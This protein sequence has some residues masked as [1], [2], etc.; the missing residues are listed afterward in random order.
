MKAYV[1][2]D[3][4]LERYAGRFVWLSINTE[5]SKNAE[6]LAKFT[7]PALPTLLVLDPRKESIVLRY[8]GGATA[9]QLI[10]MLDDARKRSTSASDS[11]LAEADKLSAAAKHQ[12]AAKLY[13]QALD[14]AEKS[15]RKFGRTAESL[16]FAL[17]TT[18]Q[19][20]LCAQRAGELYP[21]LIGTVSGISVAATGLG[22]ATELKVKDPKLIALLES[23][24][25][26]ALRNREIELSVD[27]RSGLYIALI[28]ARSALGD[29]EGAK[30]L[31]HDWVGL[32]EQAAA[33][34]RT[35]EE[36]TVYDSHRLTAYI[37]IDAPDRAIAM[38][39]QSLR[40]FPNDYNPPYR[41]AIAYKALAE[42][43]RA[44]EYVDLALVRLYGPRKILAYRLRSD[45]LLAKGDKAGAR[46][47]IADAVQYAKALPAG[48]RNE[49][50]IA[51]L[52]KK[53]SDLAR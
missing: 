1:Y 29:E 2:P 51:S 5:N 11:L 23:A 43:D 6:F 41:L 34:A 38:L 10:G 52:E 30:L 37:E 18:D 39:E 4:S 28:G 15:W 16:L 45:I 47:T 35:P 48:Q 9:P 42:Y 53:L 22:C 8:I 25:R 19:N 49:R 12:E 21:R 26:D 44:L 46:A 7:I 32:L 14:E 40:D 33:K 31:R 3:K 13:Q 36:R 24:L 50:T 17:A 20:D 27:D